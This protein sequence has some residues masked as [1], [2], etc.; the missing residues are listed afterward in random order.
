MTKSWP[1]MLLGNQFFSYFDLNLAN[2]RII[3]ILANYR[4]EN[5][6]RTV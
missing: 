1:K 4:R 6:F 5:Y 3:M 2:Q